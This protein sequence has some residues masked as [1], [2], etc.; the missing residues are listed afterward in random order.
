VFK[1]RTKEAHPWPKPEPAPALK[2]LPRILGVDYEDVPEEPLANPINAEDVDLHVR[3][4]GFGGQGVLLLG[5]VLA[6]AGLDAGLEVS[7]LPSYGPEMRSGTSNCHVRL[8]RQPIDSPL[9]TVPNVLVAMNEPSLKKF[10]AS[11]RPG[12]WVIY[13][14]DTFPSE[15]ARD[16][17]HVLAL[18]FTRMA[19]EL[20][21]SRVANMVMLGALLE[22]TG[23]LPQA[24]IDAALRRLVKNPKWLE[25][26]ERALARGRELYRISCNEAGHECL[27]GS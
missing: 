20:G 2:E 6:D 15:Y 16:D 8:A 25:L 9:V 22:I 11:V 13:N 26:D 5:E 19:D 10:D 1:D 27:C 12:G 4:A 24:S 17:V 3:V 14:G 7:W 23:T 18:P 21:D